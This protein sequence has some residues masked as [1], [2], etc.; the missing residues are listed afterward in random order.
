MVAA[1]RSRPPV[2]NVIH[3]QVASLVN[4]VGRA[5]ELDQLRA[6]FLSGVS[7]QVL[8]GMGGVGKTSL[9]RAYAQ[10]HLDDYGII[11][12]VR[13][14]DPSAL[15]AE[16]RGLLEIL[17]PPGEA[18]QVRD[19]RAVAYALLAQRPDPWLL[20]LDNVHDATA[21][22]ALLP[23]GGHVLITTRATTWPQREIVHPL[24]TR[25]AVELLTTLSQDP[26]RSSALALAEEL[27]GLP[28]AL[29]QAAS[30]TQAN[31][32]DLAT[33]LRLYQSRGAE[34]QAEGRPADYPHTVATTWQLAIEHLSPEARRFLNLFAFLAPDAIPV[35]RLF[36]DTDELARHRAIGELH[37]YSLITPAGPGAAVTVHRLVQAVTRNQLDTQEWAATALKLVKPVMPSK[38]ITA[39]VLTAWAELRTHVHALL[40]HLPPTDGN[41]LA[42]RHQMAQWPGRAGDPATSQRLFADLLALRERMLGAEHPDTLAT[43]HEMAYWTGL[44]G[45][46]RRAL[47][48]FTDLLPSRIRALGDD[49][50]GTLANRHEI[51]RWTFE[52]GDAATARD[53]FAEVLPLR[54]KV[55]GAEHVETLATAQHVAV[56]TGRAGDPRR[57]RRLFADLLPLL[58]RVLGG[59]HPDTLRVWHNLADWTGEAGDA[60]SARDML[61]ELAPIRARVLGPEHPRALFTRHELAYWI[62]EAGDVAAAR[63]LFA[64]LLSTRTRLLGADHLDTLQ[65]Q[66][67][68][69]YRIGQAGEPVRAR[70]L[71]AESVA[72][73]EQLLGA[74][75]KYTLMVRHNHAHWVGE[76]GDP[77]A[78][79]D[80]L[81]ALLPARI[82]WLGEEHHEILTTRHNLAHW[83]ALAGDPAQAREQ[84]TDLLAVRGRILGPDHVDTR[85]TRDELERWI[86]GR[87]RP[88]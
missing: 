12:W 84:L 42:F 73:Y 50:P 52:M 65:T 41:T 63:D 38:P 64:D 57:A 71:L 59:E 79:R 61:A 13:A 20:V 40:D 51:A 53:L 19:A 31:A 44:A 70:D 88:E 82:R 21:A 11:W 32:L 23:A 43:K 56:C 36:A 24:D 14:E 28:L 6:R 54:A 45:H 74:D 66:H 80:L 1:A 86:Q 35:R 58:R 34:L 87:F 26:D 39:A 49:H 78:A 47:A 10:R 18:A 85:R 16:L 3:P 68:L 83:T 60:A 75:D 7:P 33:Y 67:N 5:R 9:A 17:L 69:A 29:S 72:R 2:R 76:A 48:V 15:D 4:V 55:L 77:A 30:F 22:H 81:V 62:G 27:A 46:P 37:R 8:A 25:A